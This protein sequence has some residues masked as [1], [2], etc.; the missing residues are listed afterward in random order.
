MCRVGNDGGSV[1]DIVERVTLAGG[2]MRF[3]HLHATDL[4][5]HLR[6][7]VGLLGLVFHLF[8]GHPQLLGEGMTLPGI[9]DHG[10]DQ[11][12]DQKRPH[13][14]WKHFG[15][16]RHP[17][18]KR[19]CRQL[20]DISK[21]HVDYQRAH[22]EKQHNLEDRLGKLNEA[23]HRKNTLQSSN[24]INLVRLETVG[25]VGKIQTTDSRLGHDCNNH[26]RNTENQRRQN[27]QPKAGP[28]LGH[29]QCI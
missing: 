10:N 19:A 2:F 1:G 27:D 17:L 18:P 20:H 16:P 24:R 25:L 12:C 5:L 9:I 28:H 29:A 23:F 14:Q 26:Q 11:E 4:L 3:F 13:K 8:Q 15:N 7:A 22:T 21:L 6:R